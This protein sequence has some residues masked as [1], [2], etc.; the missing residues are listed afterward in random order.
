MDD[1]DFS[2]ALHS[3]SQEPVPYFSQFKTRSYPPDPAAPS[4]A[5]DPAQRSELASRH[6]YATGLKNVPTVGVESMCGLQSGD[7]STLPQVHFASSSNILSLTDIPAI[8]CLDHEDSN[9][10][11]IKQ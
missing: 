11:R 10:G 1:S 6:V 3:I 7:E 2:S 9:G 4:D 5:E 8:T